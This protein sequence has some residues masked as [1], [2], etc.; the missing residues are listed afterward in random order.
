[1]TP[2][3]IDEEAT[4]M[5]AEAAARMDAAEKEDYLAAAIFLQGVIYL[6][7]K[8]CLEKGRETALKLTVT[9]EQYEAQFERGEGLFIPCPV[10]S[11]ETQ[12]EGVSTVIS[13]MMAVGV[14][15]DQIDAALEHLEMTGVDGEQPFASAEAVTDK[16]APVT[17]EN[18]E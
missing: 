18:A 3:D 2:D 6:Q 9:R 12:A 8:D 10:C 11:A 13:V 4:E 17:D 7:C 14:E 16:P 5:M 15:A 1:M